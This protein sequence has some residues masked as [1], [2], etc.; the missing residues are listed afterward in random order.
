M[1][2]NVE[3]LKPTGIQ[4][5]INI[6]QISRSVPKDRFS[7]VEYGLWRIKY[8]EDEAFRKSKRKLEG[9]FAFFSP[10]KRR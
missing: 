4:N 8:Y 9:S 10:K 3:K 1:N 2:N 7:A 5:Q 6:E